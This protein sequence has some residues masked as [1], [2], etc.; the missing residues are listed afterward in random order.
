MILI[1]RNLYNWEHYNNLPALRLLIHVFMTVDM[2]S[3]S[4]L[5]TLTQLS[6]ET[7][8][9]IRQI[10]TALKKCEDSKKVTRQ[11]TRGA[12]RL[13]VIDWADYVNFENTSDK[14][15]G[16]TI[17]ERM[18]EFAMFI[19]NYSLQYDK[20][21]LLGFFDYWSECGER[22]KKMRFEKETSFSIPKRLARWKKNGQKYGKTGNSGGNQS[23]YSQAFM[24]KI[25]SK[26]QPK[27]GE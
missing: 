22:D 1:S 14:A 27:G 6:L 26:L 23:P 21:M 20:E 15:K 25:R 8:L 9:S 5:C 7:G 3:G 18:Q 12:T 19:D 17:E 13:T 4:R 11:T 2:K 10:R 24:D 16:K